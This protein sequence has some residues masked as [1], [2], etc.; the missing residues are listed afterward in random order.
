MKKIVY[1]LLITLLFI[2]MLINASSYTSAN[3]TAGKYINN[4]SHPDRYFKTSSGDLI[5]KGEVEQTIVRKDKDNKPLTISSYMFDG[6]KFWAKDAYIISEKIEKN[7]TGDAK[8]KVTE[9]VKH[10]TK[11]KGTGKYN[12]PWIFVDSFKVTVRVEEGKGTVDDLKVSTKTVDAFDSVSFDLVPEPGYKYLSNTCGEIPSGEILTINKVSKDIECSVSFETGKYSNTLPKPYSQPIHI[13]LTNSDVQY[14]FTRSNPYTFA[15]RYKEGYYT[16]DTLKTRLGKLASIPTRDGWTFKGFYVKNSETDK[17]YLI[18]EGDQLLINGSGFFESTYEL[19]KDNT[20]K[21]T[22]GWKVEPNKYKITFNRNGGTGGTGE[23]LNQVYEDDLPNITVPERPGYVF[24]GYYSTNSN[25]TYKDKYYNSTGH[26][27]KIFEMD[28]AGDLTLTAKW[29]ACAKGSYCPGNNT[30]NLCS[31]GQ[32][33]DEEGKTS[34]KNCPAGQY[35]D[36]EGQ[37]SCKNCVKASYSTEGQ[38]KCTACQSGKTTSGAGSSSCNANCTNTANA[39]QWE[40]AIWN[41]NNTVTNAC[42]IKSCQAGYKIENNTCVKACDYDSKSACQNS[43]YDS[44]RCKTDCGSCK[45]WTCK[46]EAN[47]C[48][49]HDYFCCGSSGSHCYVYNWGCAYDSHTSGGNCSNAWD[50]IAGTTE[51]CYEE[52]SESRCD[53]GYWRDNIEYSWWIG[54]NNGHH[55]ICCR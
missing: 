18:K 16:D 34:C 42:K 55:G 54:D 33:Q 17:L 7:T 19:L 10:G 3:S 23:I 8:T 9:I 50:V 36:Q 51:D 52:V 5:L 47:G 31:A 48:W 6:T 29:T 15:S 45:K 13:D 43:D 24:E 22:I 28:K 35:Q 12:D 41:T 49:V 27:V 32:Y 26:E 4:F 2:P 37:T 1:F 25:G 53:R 21:E 38:E 14:E 46:Q 30:S 20:T 11:V 39:T 44:E 40:T